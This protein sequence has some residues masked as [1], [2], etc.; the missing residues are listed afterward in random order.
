MLWAGCKGTLYL[1][2]Q[3]ATVRI[4]GAEVKCWQGSPWDA[5]LGDVASHLVA[6]RCKQLEVWL[7]G[8]LA[9]PF[10][11]PSV[12]GIKRWSEV[13]AMAQGMAETNTQL[14]GPLHVWL[15]R[16]QRDQPT[17]AVACEMSVLTAL[18]DLKASHGVHVRAV[19]PVWR[20][21]AMHDQTH[22]CL[23]MLHEASATTLLHTD[24]VGG[25]VGAATYSP[26]LPL[27]QRKAWVVRQAFSRG[28]DAE[29]VTQ[30]SLLATDITLTDACL[31]ERSSPPVQMKW[32]PHAD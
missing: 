28:V 24:P 8:G 29:R 19:T 11:V 2:D 10:L 23:L 6:Q 14:H 13:E 30:A 16:W 22:A 12:Q 1:D 21:A 20:W 25:W 4:D 18:H 31:P 5:L 9:R 7:S 27:D 15:G 3:V 32:G 26:P 17:L